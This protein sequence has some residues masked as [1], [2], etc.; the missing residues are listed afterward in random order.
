MDRHEAAVVGGSLVSLLPGTNPR[1]REAVKLASLWAEDATMKDVPDESAEMQY[2]YYLRKLK[3]LGTDAT[4]AEQVHWPDPQRAIK[5]EQVLGRINAVAGEVHARHMSLTFDAL[6]RNG[7]P[8]LNFE[9]HSNQ[10]AQFQLLSC[11]PSSSN[12]VDIVLYHEAGEGSAFTAGFLFR[13][14]RNMRVNAE[15]V[16]FN[17]L[18][19]DLLWRSKVE[20]GL[21]VMSLKDIH[22]MEI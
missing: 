21:Q 9:S 20:R 22:E 6:K 4:S 5:V 7:K 13:E 19:F 11:A 8:L 14:R 12:Y 2:R 16:R 3:H 18:Q 1:Q 17:T 10:R 15:L